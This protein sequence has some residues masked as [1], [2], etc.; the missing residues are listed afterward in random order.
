MEA[1][2]RKRGRP[3]AVYNVRVEST[4]L[5]EIESYLSDIEDSKSS[6]ESHSLWSSLNGFVDGAKFAFEALGF[7]FYVGFDGIRIYP[8]SI[9]PDFMTSKDAADEL[10]LSEQRIR[11]LLTETPPKLRG[12]KVGGNWLIERRSVEEYKDLRKSQTEV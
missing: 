2:A 9:D 12:S 8:P 4:D 3:A 11:Q 10:G 5:D 6:A 1:P 7:G